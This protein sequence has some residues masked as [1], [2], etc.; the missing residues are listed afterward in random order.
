MASSDHAEYALIQEASPRSG[1]CRMKVMMVVSL[2]VGAGL[3]LGC[4]KVANQ[5]SNADVTSMLALPTLGAKVLPQALG[6]LA[7]GGK[8]KG[9]GGGKGSYDKLGVATNAIARGGYVRILRPESYWRNEVGKVVSIDTPKGD[10]PQ[11]VLYPVTVRFDKVNYAGVNTNNF[12][13]DELQEEP[14]AAR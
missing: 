6:G 14:A 4:V 10:A 2:F 5:V 8:G 3:G 7:P 1:N 12:A 13:L 9:K 11:K